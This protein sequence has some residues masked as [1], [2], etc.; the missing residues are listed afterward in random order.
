MS[1]LHIGIQVLKG[2]RMHRLLQSQQI[3]PRL[4]RSK[5]TI[6]DQAVVPMIDPYIYIYLFTCISLQGGMETKAAY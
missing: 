2:K 1:A 3:E 4:F 5:S 6:A